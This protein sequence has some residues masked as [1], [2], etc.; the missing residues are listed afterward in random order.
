MGKKD[1]ILITFLWFISMFGNDAYYVPLRTSLYSVKTTSC[2]TWI[3]LKYEQVSVMCILNW[4]IMTSESHYCESRWYIGLGGNNLV[5]PFY[6]RSLHVV[7]NR[8]RLTGPFPAIC[9]YGVNPKSSI[10][11]KTW[12]LIWWRRAWNQGTSLT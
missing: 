12:L 6:T 9:G 4:D 7:I 2:V 3:G 1:R 8:C 5:S 10:P 11:L